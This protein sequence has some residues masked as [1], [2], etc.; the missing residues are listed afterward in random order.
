MAT[1]MIEYE[2][3]IRLANVRDIHNRKVTVPAPHENPANRL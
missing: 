1:D 2:T 3:G